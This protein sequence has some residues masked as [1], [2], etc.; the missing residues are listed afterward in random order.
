MQTKAFGNTRSSHNVFFVYTYK[1]QATYALH[2]DE[3]SPDI[4]H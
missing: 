4:R 2:D 3:K 1:M